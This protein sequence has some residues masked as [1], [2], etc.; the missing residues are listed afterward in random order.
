MV[1]RGNR[2][3]NVVF[4]TDGQPSAAITDP[5]QI[6]ANVRAANTANARLFTFGVGTD[7]NRLLLE[8]LASE[9]RGATSHIA[10]QSKLKED[11][12]TFFANVSQPVLSS[13]QLDLGPVL[14][15]R[16]H[17]RELPDLYKRSQIRIFGRYKNAEDLRDVSIFLR[18]VMNE[19][20]QNFE[21]SGL[22][23]PLATEDKDFLPKLWAGERVAALLSEIRLYGE[24]AELKDEVI[25]LARQ[26]NLVTP[27]TSMYVPTTAELE[28]EK[29]GKDDQPVSLSQS[30]EGSGRGTGPLA[31]NAIKSK[32]VDNL[33][34]NGR[35]YVRLAQLSPGVT[36]QGAAPQGAVVDS[37]GAVVPNATVT[38]RDQNT[39]VTRQVATDAS[40]NYS[41]AGLPPGTYNVEVDAPGFNKTI[42]N[43]M[44]V[45]PGQI[46][47]A[48][49]VVS[50][51][52]VSEAVTVMAGASLVQRDTA[53]I[54]VNHESR[55]LRDLPSLAPVDSL[56]RLSVGATSQELKMPSASSPGTDRNAEF[57]FWFNGNGSRS[58]SF[59]ID[60][61]DNDDIDGR[62]AISVNNFDSIESLYVMTTRGTGDATLTGASSV[63]LQTRS[64]TNEF[65]GTA[66]DFHL[67]R[68]LSAMS[69]LERRSGLDRP[70]LLRNNRYGGTFGGPLRRDRMFFFGAF[71]GEAESSVRFI[72]STSSLLT[73]TGRGLESLAAAFP[74]SP[75]I[76]DLIRRG[77]LARQIGS[78]QTSRTFLIPVFGVPVEFGQTTRLIES[79]AEGY[80]ATGRFDFVASLQDTIRA[81]Y[82]FSTRSATNDIGRLA[83]G[84]AGASGARAQFA[85]LQWTRTIS[86][87]TV[88]EA[89]FAFHRSRLSLDANSNDQSPGVSAGL[90]GLDYGPS[91]FLPSSH[92]STL[93]EAADTLTLIVGSHNL[94]LGGQ[95]R[96][97][98]AEFDYLPGR[99]GQYSFATFE[100]FTLGRPSTIAAAIGDPRSQF[101][102][103]H[104]HYFFDD[105][106]RVKNNLSLSMGL[107]YENASQPINALARRL[108]ERESD[109]SSALFDSSLPLTSPVI[110]G[111]NRDKNNFAPRLG[112]AYTPRFF[113][114]G[115]DLFGFDKTV[116]RG[117]AQLS[118]D[119][120]AFRPL[121]EVA[122]S[123]PARVLAVITP[124]LISTLPE[125]PTALGAS[126]LRSLLGSDPL[127]YARTD[128]AADFR[129]PYS[130][131]WNLTI[132]REIKGRSAIEASYT[133]SRGSKLI[134]AT[135]GNP[136]PGGS[137]GPLRIY[138]TSGRSIYHALQT[139]ADIRAT[140]LLEGGL[141]YTL[142][143]LI[144]DVPDNSS[145]IIGSVGDRATLASGSLLT[146]AQNPFDNARGERGLSSLDRRHS[147]AGHFVL[148]FPWRRDQGGVLG[149]V[150]GGWKASGIIQAASGSPF[151][152]V[153][154]IGYRAASFAAIFSDRQGA[155]RPFAGNAAA[156]FDAVAFSNAANR[157]LHLFLNSD[158]TPFISPTGFIIGDRRGFRAGSTDQARFIYNDYVVEQMA[159]ALGLSA[160]AFGNTFAAGRA[161]GDIGRNT[162]TGPR[163]ASFDFALL[164]TTKLTEKVQLQFRAE[165][166]NLFN[167]P[168]R[169]RPNSIVENAG[170][171][172][173]LDLG[174]ADALPRRARFALKLIF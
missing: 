166:Y 164:K 101:S 5:N 56:A 73:P 135:D 54:T 110:A 167:H 86:P 97:R 62:P 111:L 137:E 49:V 51:G 50:P 41:V 4:V 34:V 129:T 80:E 132:S 156:P 83:S 74:T 124:D 75:T 95:W 146:F 142:S 6:A 151:T 14:A 23:F 37:N 173:F 42:V 106:W 16:I 103:S 28:A 119:Q 114:F 36:S 10:D 100:D 141:S 122:A 136:S 133:G 13:L 8:K 125:F 45:S 60:G 99:Q 31:Q 105:V 33:P 78:P 148:T 94:T 38:I 79:T 109:P 48:G 120:T 92:A 63:D 138:E 144:D 161:F 66:F 71:E 116:I 104:H 18:G 58:T 55:M 12:S 20:A 96:S 158:G 152:P 131:V 149:R 46:T 72:D 17:P 127:K 87:Q 118:Y 35:N 76:R 150:L 165:Y 143:K 2:A 147:L 68:R 163:F 108:R 27:Y 44:V 162:L 153:Q 21:F 43:N 170:G 130:A 112:F 121:A 40:G 70:P 57:R 157:A 82:W 171:F 89:S 168:N 52:S 140:S 59:S 107:S 159:R 26:F 64:G 91:A 1:E 3:Q 77:P 15:D 32:Q 29:A 9:N 22:N 65:H 11:V 145:H 67:N 24:K 39:G 174:E 88:N 61:R 93:Y 117:G 154:Q 113:V 115:R 123:A 134:R 126:D 19:Q 84:Y 102:Q 53:Q 81:G 128:F 47:G 169:P 85:S 155:V 98:A 139:R 30:G 90:R 172:G 69:P 25:A 160:D 7:I